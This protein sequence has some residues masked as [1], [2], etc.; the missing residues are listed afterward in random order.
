[1]LGLGGAEVVKVES[2]ARPDGTRFGPA[3]FFNY[4]H[5]GHES[6]VL[7]FRRDRQRLTDLLTAAD[8]VLEGSRPRG[9]RQLGIIAG[10]YVERG[11]IWVSITAY[12]RDPVDEN[13]VGFG[14]DV[15][16]GAGLSADLDGQ[17][18]P[19]GDAIADPLAGV[20]AAAAA[21]MCLT[22]DRGALLDVS[23]HD[24]A[25]RAAQPD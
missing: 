25:R 12:G 21:A 15:A 20:Y 24:V 7:D 5:E 19:V 16:V 3:R 4:L 6:V 22:G 13:R 17:P 14:D 8:V 18:I 1:L 23:M 2:V 9:L 11:A 10:E